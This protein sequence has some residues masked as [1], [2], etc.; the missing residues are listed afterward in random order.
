MKVRPV[1]TRAVLSEL[2]IDGDALPSEFLIFAP[3]DNASTK[4]PAIWDQPA[5]AS[6]M[7]FVRER[8]RVDYMI[9]LEHRSLDKAATALTKDAADAMGWFNIELRGLELWAVNVRWTPEGKERLLAKKQRYTSPAFYWLDEENGRVG[10]LVNV[11]LVSMPATHDQPALVAA[12]RLAQ[13]NAASFGDM[14]R[15][16]E[17][18]LREM[19]PAAP[20]AP[21]CGAW[22]CDVY[23]DSFVYEYE[24][25]FFQAPFTYASGV[26]TIAGTP[27]KVVRQYVPATPAAPT[28]LARDGG[29]AKG[30]TVNA[31]TMVRAQLVRSKNTK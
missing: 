12:S 11:A 28:G 10:E 21:G 25:A 1:A 23:P 7:A 6:V 5:A 9:D 18:V 27:V 22:V 14:S 3:G 26:A 8:G 17:A 31:L 20:G 19:Y 13:R 2:A 16:L 29:R 15:A 24:G 4:G 30:R